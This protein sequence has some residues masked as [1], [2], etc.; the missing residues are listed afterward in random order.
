MPVFPESRFVVQDPRCRLRDSRVSCRASFSPA[1]FSPLDRTAT[2]AAF[3]VM[4][5]HPDNP[6][7]VPGCHN[8]GAC[9]LMRRS[10]DTR[11]RGIPF[12]AG[13]YHPRYYRRHA[14]FVCGTTFEGC[15]SGCKQTVTIIYFCRF[16]GLNLLTTDYIRDITTFVLVTL[17]LGK[18]V[19]KSEGRY[20]I[21]GQT[22][23]YQT[24]IPERMP[25]RPH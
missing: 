22:V 7:S 20:I 9:L 25:W 13:R 17:V 19:L 10:T 15:L 4:S 16:F 24:R 5:A 23:W 11:A 14:Q 3:G 18:P 8:S 1:R 21:L 2:Q 6:I 12:L